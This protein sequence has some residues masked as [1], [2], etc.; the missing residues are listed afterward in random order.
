MKLL[1]PL[2]LILGAAA[3]PIIILYMLK[4]RR[5]EVKI[6]SVYLWQLVLKDYQA[7]SPWQ[8]LKR[9]LL[10]LLQLLILAA[11]VMALTRP[12]FPIPG[13]KANALIVLLD[14]SASMQATDL[15]PSRFE[16]ARSEIKTIISGMGSGERMTLILV[17]EQ[18]LILA[19][20]QADKTALNQAL[21]SASAS[22]GTANWESAFALAAGVATQ[23]QAVP[24]AGADAST[25]LIVSDGG[26]PR[27]ELPPLPGIVRFL[28]IG[29]NGDNLA[30]SALSL[31]SSAGQGQLYARLTNYGSEPREALFSLYRDEALIH[32]Q[33]ISLPPGEAASLLL[34]DLS[35]EQ[36][37]YRAQLS[38]PAGVQE[39][40]DFL[41]LDNI[42]ISTIQTEQTG[43]V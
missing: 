7:N 38:P 23:A 4:L 28:P 20:N 11:V 25:I 17:Q 13:I 18:P 24:E 32:A 9:N 1:N 5:Q 41:E 2:A 14:A 34:D 16:T 10:L 15:T 43:R 42:A 33:E 19:S 6:S 36:A 8:R 29:Q 30:I 40:G 35:L 3:I 27:T 37:I 12:V 26:L 22:N 39:E 21:E 31:G